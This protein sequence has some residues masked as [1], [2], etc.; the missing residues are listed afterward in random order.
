M[1]QRYLSGVQPS[2]ELHLGNYIGAMRHH[3][4]AQDDAYYF[5]ADYHALTSLGDAEALRQNVRHV[6]AAYLAL[7]L[8]PARAT[9][10][11]QSD[12]PEV[13]ELTWLLSNV[14]AMGLL[15]RAHSYKD[16]IAK[17]LQPKVGL[18]TYP[19]LM[20][21]DILAYDSDVVPVGKDQAQHLEITRD[22]AI[23]FNALYGETFKLPRIVLGTPELVPGIDG[24][25]MSKS[26]NNT[27]PIFTR[28]KAL[29]SLVMSIKTDSKGLDEPKDPDTCTVYKLYT[30]VAS[31][32]EQ[33]EMAAAYRAG[34][35]GYGHAK[36][37]LLKKLEETFGPAYERY[38]ALLA[39]PDDLEDRLRVG[40]TRARAEAQIVL[41]RARRACGL[42]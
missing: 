16:K 10:F 35:Y 15:E 40:A 26:Y 12:V 8:D 24:E 27:L 31:P 2:G 19:I 1:S 41:G 36:L 37:A 23:A 20:A 33:A 29:K 42:D 9:F 38:D 32:A 17:G 6:A 3:I 21:A 5:I 7:G 14:A 39:R 30:F 13:C 22:L 28:G 11:R 18:F 4:E 25:K 34:G